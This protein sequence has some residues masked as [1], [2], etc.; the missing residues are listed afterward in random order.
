VTIFTPAINGQ[1]TRTY[2]KKSTTYLLLL[3]FAF[4][5]KY[6]YSH[7]SSDNLAWVL[8][9]TASLVVSVT[10]LRFVYEAHTGYVSREHSV[11]IA[12]SCAGIN[13]MIVALLMAGAMGI[14]RLKTGGEI[15]VWLGFT[16]IGV[17]LLTLVINTIRIVGAIYLYEADIG[18]GWLT[19]ARVHRLEGI[20]IYFFAL[21]LFHRVVDYVLTGYHRRE[22]IHAPCDEKY[23]S[24]RYGWVPAGWYILVLVGI[25]LANQAFHH[26]PAHFMEHGLTVIIGSALVLFVLFL[27]RWVGYRIIP[28]RRS[29][30]QLNHQT[31]N[32]Q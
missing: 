10:D 30:P 5:L 19:P 9:P 18:H 31:R 4:A 20:G 23:R 22:S 7:A 24:L 25:P 2:L 32:R 17:Y 15:I 21:C 3:L 12:P 28:W 27:I 29:R 13:F 26:H 14:S 8:S 16:G 11:I 6:H 1:K